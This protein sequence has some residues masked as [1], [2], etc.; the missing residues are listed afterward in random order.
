MTLSQQEMNLLRDA[1][2]VIVDDERQIHPEQGN[3]FWI[4]FRDVLLAMVIERHE[5]LL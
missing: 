4:E 3:N 5:E 1:V 2:D